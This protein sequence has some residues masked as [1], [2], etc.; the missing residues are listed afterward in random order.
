MYLKYFK[1]FFFLIIGIF[2]FKW[3]YDFFGSV[4]SFDIIKKN[5]TKL[6]LIILAHIPTLFFDAFAWRIF[7][8]NGNLS[9]LWSFIITWISQASG[10]F[11]PTG[12]VTGEFVRIYLGI[13]KG[14]SFHESSSTVLADLVI[15]TLSL[16]IMASFSVLVVLSVN[17][18][19]FR[20]EQSFYVI[21]SLFIL[22]C[23]CIFFYF[24]IRKRLIKSCLTK[25]HL[26]NFK[27][28]KKNIK[29]LFKLDLSL[30][31]LSK[32]KIDVLKATLTRLLGWISG[33]FEIYVFLMIIGVEVS[34]VDVILI[35]AFTGLIKSIVFFIPGALGV[36]ELAFVL[37]GGYVGLGDSISFAVALGRRIREIVFGLPAV[38]AWLMIFEQKKKKG[39]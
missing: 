4:E 15:A 10:K 33:A 29:F 22:L 23:G 16:F 12:T 1:F 2:L 35:E 11:F 30:H 21:S 37:I 14:L 32:K 39:L 9:I 27:L 13:R 19:F 17:I 25:K 38:V 36:Q 24:F 6:F 20:N 28:K 26:F 8:K 3:V 34:F 18:N 5:K 31:N 7:I